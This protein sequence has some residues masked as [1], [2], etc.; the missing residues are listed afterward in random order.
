MLELPPTLDSSETRL[1]LGR[2]S[3]YAARLAEVDAGLTRMRRDGS[4][5]RLGQLPA[6]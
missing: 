4:L 2:S 3:P 5:V 6:E 1:M